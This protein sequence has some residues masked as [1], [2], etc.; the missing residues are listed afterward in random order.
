MPT[1]FITHT[2]LFSFLA[3]ADICELISFTCMNFIR[4]ASSPKRAGS[5][6]LDGCEK[7]SLGRLLERKGEAGGGEKRLGDLRKKGEDGTI[8][9]APW[10]YLSVRDVAGRLQRLY[11]C[12]T[13]AGIS[14]ETICNL[15]KMHPKPQAKK[16]SKF[17]HS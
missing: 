15:Q 11:Q 8:G 12:H 5:G 4:R 2:P 3:F 17:E 10:I 13:R 1:F 16:Y 14:N 9:R 6:W 7:L